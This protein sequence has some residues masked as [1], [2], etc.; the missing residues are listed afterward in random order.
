MP[1]AGHNPNYVV[2]PSFPLSVK[3]NSIMDAKGQKVAVVFTET[4]GATADYIVG[5]LNEYAEKNVL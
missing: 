3:G 4:A 2:R 5:I 1:N